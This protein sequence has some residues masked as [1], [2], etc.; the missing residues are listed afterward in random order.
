MSSPIEEPL[1][2]SAPLARRLAPS[3][4]RVDPASGESCAWSHGIWQYLRLMGMV[5]TPEHQADFFDRAF[6]L[7]AAATRT[8]RVLVAGTADYAML[9]QA[10]SALRRHG[11]EPEVTVL[12]I[13]PTPLELNRW[14][15]ERARARVATV[16]ADILDFRDARG[17]DA[18]CTHSFF[19][20][21]APERRPALAAKWH[22]LLRPGGRVITVNRLRPASGAK[23][24]EFSAEQAARYRAVVLQAA[25]A[26]PAAVAVPPAEL[27]AEAERY[28]SRPGGYPLR[29]REDLEG[30]LTAAGFTMESFSAAPVSGHARTD[31]SG[32]TAPGGALY[33]SIIAARA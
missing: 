23:K 26:L 13:C 11:A 9:H 25:A 24:S 15:G 32:P 28:A 33:A 19:G 31:I 17:F 22:E 18:V 1:R 6:A 20:R 29:S 3:L 7:V 2:E 12:D 14:Y 21:I 10:V 8:P 16:P 4:C 5:T 27:V 30:L